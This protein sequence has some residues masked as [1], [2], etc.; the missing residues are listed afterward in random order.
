M[1]WG[2][3]PSVH[4]PGRLYRPAALCYHRRCSEPAALKPSRP[5]PSADREERETALPSFRKGDTV[6]PFF[7]LARRPFNA[8]L[9]AT[10]VFLALLPV[11]AA[12][13]SPPDG[14]AARAVGDTSPRSMSPQ[15][16]PHESPAKRTLMLATT[17]SV[18]A[19]G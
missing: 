5:G 10:A 18:D 13:G 6:R 11:T 9:V 3:V 4:V 1:N 15:R 16:S 14:K 2:H 7:P 8:I 17:T 12:G 19:T